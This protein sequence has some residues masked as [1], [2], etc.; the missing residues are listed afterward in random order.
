MACNA[1]NKNDAVVQIIAAAPGS[2]IESSIILQRAAYL[3]E[4]AEVGY[5]FLFGCEF[6]SPYCEELERATHAAKSRGK[7]DIEYTKTDWGV[8]NTTYKTSIPYNGNGSKDDYFRAIVTKAA[9]CN[10]RQLDLAATAIYYHS[11]KRD[12]PWER[13]KCLK[14]YDRA[15]GTLEMSQKLYNELRAMP[16]LAKLPKISEM[17][18]QINSR[19]VYRD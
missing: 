8:T 5:G 15:N 12:D 18:N 4:V 13:I 7:I 6:C 2:K 3:L 1:T 16:A 19:I 14:A 9:K 11:I 10:E 17:P